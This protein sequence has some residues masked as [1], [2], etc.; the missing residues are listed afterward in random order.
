MNKIIMPSGGQTTDESEIVKWHKKVGDSVQRGDVLFEI[1]TDKA[2][3]E[4][5]SYCE[6]YLRAAYYQEG[7][8]VAAGEIVAYVGGQDEAL[9][10]EEGTKAAPPEQAAVQTV[11]EEEE[12]E[13]QPIMGKRPQADAPVPPQPKAVPGPSE[14]QG[15]PLASPRAK[16]AARENGVDLQKVAPGPLGVIKY[17]NVLDYLEC[18]KAEQSDYEDVPLSSMRRTIARRM[19]ESVDVAPHYTVS[20]DV[21]M[22][23]CIALRKKINDYLGGEVKVSFNDLL[24][25][26]VAKA[27]EAYPL[28]NSSYLD[29]CIRMHRHVHVGL[30]VGVDN[31]LLVPVVRNVDQLSLAQIARQNTENIQ[32]AKAGKLAPN[33]MSGGTITISNLGMF[34]VDH[35]TAV[36]N[37]PESCILAVGRIAERAVSVDHTI[38]SRDMMNITASFD[39][40]VI[41]GAV[42][43][44]FLRQ[45]KRLLEQPELLLV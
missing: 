3:L 42:G 36:I 6:G 29:D 2:T 38:V 32:K 20:M 43:A 31:G 23:A 12:E 11:E 25:K 26:C 7:D 10:Q 28:V 44:Q 21:D 18:Q 17:Q 13:Y 35:F 4:V 9:P 24:A 8:K 5:E 1:E 19:R 14:V 37:Q 22:G 33:D 15:K 27:V 41:D 40:R 34:D 30:A 16:Q 45:V 39:H